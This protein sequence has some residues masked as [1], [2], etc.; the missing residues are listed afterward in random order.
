MVVAG[1]KNITPVNL[2][3]PPLS[4]GFSIGASRRN[5]R[6]I[7]SPQ[8]LGHWRYGET[9][10][11]FKRIRLIFERSELARVPTTLYPPL[12]VRYR[13]PDTVTIPDHRKKSKTLEGPINE[14]R[15]RGGG[16][17]CVYR[18]WRLPNVC[19]VRV[20]VYVYNIT[21]ARF[22]VCACALLRT[23]LTRRRAHMCTCSRHGND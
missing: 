7:L 6:D 19:D 11:R 5:G 1:L 12:R 10:E 4:T 17:A 8:L 18:H 15:P 14:R 2:N 23:R 3:L 16:S 20:P 21:H 9:P 22:G 13:Q